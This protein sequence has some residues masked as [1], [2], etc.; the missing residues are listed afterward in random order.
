MYL[1]D[2]LNASSA[3][4]RSPTSSF[5]FFVG[6]P[7]F[8]QRPVVLGSHGL[9]CSQIVPSLFSSNSHL[10]RR[11]KPVKRSGHR[12]SWMI[13]CFAFVDHLKLG[14]ETWPFWLSCGAHWA[15]L[16]HFSKVARGLNVPWIGCCVLKVDVLLHHGT[17]EIAE[18][19]VVEALFPRRSG[20]QFW[21][22]AS[23]TTVRPA[24]FR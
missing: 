18:E 6:C 8:T 4:G 23:S 2:T 9:S 3:Q 22:W 1:L 24:F 13:R 19:K 21:V 15:S 5:V 20:A 12:H 10:A 11:R 17:A 7:R 14:L 16:W